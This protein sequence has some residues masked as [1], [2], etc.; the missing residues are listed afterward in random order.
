MIDYEVDLTIDCD[1][2]GMKMTEMECN[3]FCEKCIDYEVSESMLR[4]YM[5]NAARGFWVNDKDNVVGFSC[6]EDKERYFKGVRDG[7]S[8]VLFWLCD[9]LNIVEF[10]E[11]QIGHSLEHCKDPHQGDIPEV[12][13][14]EKRE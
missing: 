8:D 2:C 5:K 11:N 4:H 13:F 3:A 9:E 12:D 6:K 14:C 7:I 1:R 10:F